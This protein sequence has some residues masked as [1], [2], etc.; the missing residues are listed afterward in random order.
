MYLTI[1]KDFEDTKQ[2]YDIEVCTQSISNSC[3]EKQSKAYSFCE[4]LFVE[5][6]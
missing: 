6:L 5:Y 4:A 2:M 3:T 1:G